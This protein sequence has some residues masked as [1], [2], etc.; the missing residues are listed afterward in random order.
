MMRL[1]NHIVFTLLFISFCSVAQDLETIKDQKFVTYTGGIS[2]NNTFY[3]AIGMQ[4]QRDP[5]FW[6]LTANI[7]F[8]FLNVVQVPFSATISQQQKSFNQP[9]PFNRFGLSP[10]YK[11][12]TG[13]F[14]HRSMTFSQFSLA[15]T[16]FFGAGLEYTPKN[17]PWR[18]S[19]MYGRLA[20]P[21]ERFARDGLIFAEPTYRRIAFGTKVGYEKD[22]IST[23]LILFRSSDDENSINVPDSIDVKPEEN[24][25]L[26][27]V[28]KFKFLSVFTMEIDYAHSMLTRDKTAIERTE[29][30]LSFRNNLGSL[31]N[32]NQSSTFNNALSSKLTFNGN[33]FQLNFAYRR[34]DPGF[35]THGSSF[36]NNDLEDISGGVALPLFEGRVSLSANAGVQRNNLENQLAAQVSRFIFSTSASV[37]VSERL[38][39]SIAYSNFS[40]DTRQTL[41]QDDLLSD[42]LEF[43]Q[44]T[45][46]GTVTANY[47]LG[48][49][50]QSNVFGTLSLQDATD[51]DGNASIFTNANV[52]FSTVINTVWRLN[53]SANYN[54]N[55]TMDSET[56]SVGPGFGVGRSLWQ[57]KVQMNLAFNMFNSY[58]EGDLQS[59]I[60][61]VRWTAS[62][63]LGQHHSISLN[64][65]YTDRVSVQEGVNNSTKEV[66][67]NV[68]YAF[69]F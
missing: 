3:N 44:V 15:G 40:T 38:N 4:S 54:K 27:L 66:R 68:N 31:F 10:T 30:E 8:N 32:A 55:V 41:L 60:A 49:A 24:L 63:S 52:G 69:R 9:Q 51:S 25:V 23:H 57:N 58:L 2:F 21:V 19:A 34:I 6:Q 39:T 61:T 26:G 47:T 7:N 35:T 33:L 1:K 59:R 20:K 67:G 17:N 53:T 43:F 37:A 22:D 36:L 65:F 42:T 28:T 16:I 46:N 45:R 48:D 64:A 5:Y 12:L 13:H 62:S 29:N 11:S 56:T 14:G 50:K 18:A